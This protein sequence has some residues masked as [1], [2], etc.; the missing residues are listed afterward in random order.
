MNACPTGYG[1]CGAAPPRK[2]PDNLGHGAT[3]DAR[4]LSDRHLVHAIALAKGGE[5]SEL[6]HG[7]TAHRPTL[8][9]RVVRESDLVQQVRWRPI[10]AIAG[11]GPQYG[12]SADHPSTRWRGSPRA[13]LVGGSGAPNHEKAPVS[14]GTGAS[15]P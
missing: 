12:V 4:S 15:V 11:H 14:P 13:G 3:V 1:A 6:P 5:H 10:E 7:Q 9:N 8:E 2:A